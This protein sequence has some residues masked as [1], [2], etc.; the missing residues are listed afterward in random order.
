MNIPL[1]PG[2]YWARNED[3]SWYNLIVRIG[4]KVPVL[5]FDYIF[6]LP[7]GRVIMDGEPITRTASIIF[8]P[9]IEEPD[10]DVRFEAKPGYDFEDI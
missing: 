2:L 3:Y 9:K 5:Y 6:S 7:K 10:V 4:G 1:K 8:G